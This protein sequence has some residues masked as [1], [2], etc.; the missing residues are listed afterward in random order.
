MH[1][2]TGDL[3]DVILEDS[4]CI[5]VS[6]AE[7]CHTSVVVSVYKYEIIQVSRPAVQVYAFWN[8]E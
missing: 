8:A 6:L 7:I 5:E 3:N 4:N 2:S 1:A